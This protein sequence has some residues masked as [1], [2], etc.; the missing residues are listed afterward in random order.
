[1]ADAQARLF[2]FSDAADITLFEP[3]D[4]QYTDEPVVWAIHEAYE[5]QYLVPRGCPRVMYTSHA[6]SDPAAVDRYL[7]DGCAHTVVA[8]EAAW[9][10]RARTGRL[11][12]YTLPSESFA[13][14]DTYDGAQVART[15]VSAEPVR[16]VRVDTIDDLLGA[17][18]AKGVEIRV[19]PS[20]WQLRDRI[21]ESGL[22]FSF[23][24][25]RNAIPRNDGA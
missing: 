7:A 6:D 4:S 17:L 8:I 23:I 9:L 1:M 16:P 18:A 20:L 5:H 19:V 15:W 13:P 11:Y 14:I 2:H 24:R 25:M 21:L 10:E 22:P 3:R 12:R